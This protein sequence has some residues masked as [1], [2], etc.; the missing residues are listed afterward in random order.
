MKMAQQPLTNTTN[1]VVNINHNRA[2][3]YKRKNSQPMCNPNMNEWWPKVRQKQFNRLLLSTM[4]S[5]TAIST[6][7]PSRAA[8]TMSRIS[9]SSTK[10][11]F[12]ICLWILILWNALNFC[13]CVGKCFKFYPFLYFCFMQMQTY[14]KSIAI[15]LCSITDCWLLTR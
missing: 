6:T 8:A 3:N 14:V 10:P 11:M 5:P 13:S 15:L 2:G 7:N 9:L 1:L 4:Q 12:T